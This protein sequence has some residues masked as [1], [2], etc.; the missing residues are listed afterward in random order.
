MKYVAGIIYATLVGFFFFFAVLAMGSL[1]LSLH[2]GLIV[3]TL[4]ILNSQIF[5]LFCGYVYFGQCKTWFS[6]SP[7]CCPPLK[8]CSH[9]ESLLS[10]GFF[11]LFSCCSLTLSKDE[12]VPF[13]NHKEKGVNY[14]SGDLLL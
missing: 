13:F 2:G 14:P 7:S 12:A 9:R 5:G 10:E 11:F 8:A 1:L 3:F 6:C 4:A